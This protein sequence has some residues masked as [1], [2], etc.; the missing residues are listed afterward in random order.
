MWGWREG[1]GVCGLGYWSFRE[2]VDIEV[3]LIFVNFLVMIE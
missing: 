1:K 2:V 3:G